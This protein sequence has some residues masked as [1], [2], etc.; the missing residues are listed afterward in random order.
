AAA[1]LPSGLALG[2]GTG[3]KVI[4]THHHFY[5]PAYQKAWLDWEDQRK[6][7]HFKTQVDWTRQRA[8]EE[9]DKNNV[10]TAVLSLAST[11]GLW[12]DGG[13]E[14]ASRMVRITSDFAAEMVRDHP[15]RFGLFAPLSMLDTDATLKELEYA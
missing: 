12:F 5:A 15:G 11:P 7:P 10:R 13:A 6:V 2:E 1:A 9:L 14:A 3:A 4:D 8:V